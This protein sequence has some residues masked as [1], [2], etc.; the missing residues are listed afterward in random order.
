[1]SNNDKAENANL[2]KQNDR[3][4]HEL[5]HLK[6]DKETHAEEIEILNAEI[7][8]LKDQV[9]W[10][11]N[12]YHVKVWVLAGVGLHRQIICTRSTPSSLC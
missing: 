6:K 11:T 4:A 3:V 9:R 7:L 2:R 5:S 12:T 10:T 1:M 8:D